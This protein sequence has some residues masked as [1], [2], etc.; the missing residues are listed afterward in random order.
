MNVIFKF[1][2]LLSVSGLIS[3]EKSNYPII[4]DSDKL[5]GYWINPVIVDTVWQYERANSFV[6][7][8][9]GISFQSGQLFVERKNAGWCGTPPI[10][11]SNYDGTWTKSASLINVTVGYWGGLAYYQWKIISVDNKNLTIYRI[12]ETYLSEEK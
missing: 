7:D 11:Y 2:L 6:M 10:S 1:F 12:K 8:A 3:C 5:L 9:G 4:N